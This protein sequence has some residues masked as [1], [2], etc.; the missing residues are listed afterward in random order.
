MT[1]LG[2][3][4]TAEETRGWPFGPTRFE[5]RFGNARTRVVSGAIG[6]PIVLAAVWLGGWFFFSFVCLA[7]VGAM[8][9]FYWI[10]EAKGARPH[11]VLGIV[12]GLLF[13][14]VF[15]HGTTDM[16]VMNALGIQYSYGALYFVRAVSFAI[17]IAL[18][19]AICLIVEMR[20]SDSSPLL[21]NSSTILG[22]MYVGFFLSSLVGIRQLF[23]GDPLVSTMATSAPGFDAGSDLSISG[24]YMLMAVLVS[25]WICDSAAYYV[26]RAFGRHKLAPKISPK[27]TWEG[28]V[29][30]A[31]F[32]IASMIGF[33]EFLLGFLSIAD[34]IV[35]GLIVGVLGQVGDL[36]ESHFKRD[37]GVKDSSQLIP[38]HGGVFDRLDSLMF[39]SPLV[40]AYIVIISMT[41]HWGFFY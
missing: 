3:A 1:N 34:A 31:V 9:E 23:G 25:I 38:G 11:K 27:K 39:V 4:V 41:R 24:A 20:R 19:V 8:L 28:A 6:I 35:L 36:A 5:R 32:A 26:G 15:F 16:F 29:G 13:A 7:I 21:N 10:A 37:A 30:G 17:V 18:L 33:Q 14:F 2:T 12:F 22:V 40:Y